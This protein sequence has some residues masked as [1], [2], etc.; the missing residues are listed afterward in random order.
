M[1][2]RIQVKIIAIGAGGH[3]L[4]SPMCV[5]KCVVWG[6]IKDS[7]NIF[8]IK[9]IVCGTRAVVHMFQWVVLFLCFLR[10]F[11]IAAL[12]FRKKYD[13]TISAVVFLV[14]ELEVFGVHRGTNYHCCWSK[15]A[16]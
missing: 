1:Q 13:K 2:P 16:V 3:D 9:V 12:F 5:R 11:G 4:Y 10:Y 8:M 6:I 7:I 14:F 15:L